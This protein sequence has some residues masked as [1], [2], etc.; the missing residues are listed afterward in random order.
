MNDWTYKKGETKPY[1]W[2][3][4]QEQFNNLVGTYNNLTWNTQAKPITYWND[5]E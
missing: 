4:E 2:N 5:K 3:T 1:Y